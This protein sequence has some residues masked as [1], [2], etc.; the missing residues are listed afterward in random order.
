MTVV[1]DASVACKGFVKES[2]SVH[3]ERVLQASDGLV[4]PDLIVAG[5]CNVA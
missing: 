2:D 5:A 1:V 3:A 4:A